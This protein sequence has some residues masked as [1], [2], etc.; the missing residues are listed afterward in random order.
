MIRELVLTFIARLGASK[1]SSFSSNGNFGLV[2]LWK[3]LFGQAYR[4]LFVSYDPMSRD[5]EASKLQRIV[6][7]V[8]MYITPSSVHI[9]INF[10]HCA[11]AERDEEAN[12]KRRII[13]YVK[14]MRETR[15]TAE[16]GQSRAQ[17]LPRLFCVFVIQRG[18][19]KPTMFLRF[20]NQTGGQF[21]R[22]RRFWAR[23]RDP[24]VR[25]RG[26]WWR[27][28]GRCVRGPGEIGYG[29]RR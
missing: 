29:R 6:N 14:Q 9:I 23:R 3:F 27:R 19:S 8:V 16:D 12:A 24:H 5:C 15:S 10:G 13:A 2:V 21:W 1:N 25:R 11:Y 26:M 17:L 7:A 20:R 4:S 18:D 22:R 28:R